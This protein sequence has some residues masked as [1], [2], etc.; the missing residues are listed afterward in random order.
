MEVQNE[1]AIQFGPLLKALFFTVSSHSRRES[2]M[3][4]SVLRRTLIL[5][6]R[7]YRQDLT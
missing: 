5:S 4:V 7:L 3:S 1:G 2:K 6:C